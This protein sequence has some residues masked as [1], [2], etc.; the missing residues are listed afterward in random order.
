MIYPREYRKDVNVVVNLFRPILRQLKI[1]KFEDHD[2]VYLTDAKQLNFIL[3]LPNICITVLFAD[4]EKQNGVFFHRQIDSDT[5]DC[6]IVINSRFY[7]DDLMHAKLCG[8]HEFC[9]FLALF[10]ALTSTSSIIQRETFSKRLNSRIDELNNGSFTSFYTA[11][12][13]GITS[14]VAETNNAHYFLGIEENDIDYVSIHK[15]LLFSKELFEE[16]FIDYE[17]KTFST[18]M[19]SDDIEDRRHGVELYIKMVH[20]A[21]DE[22]SVDRKIAADRAYKWAFD[23]LSK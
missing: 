9:H 20:K 14:D 22:K 19:K 11:L 18:L 1:R 13:Q 21:A 16:Y 5:Y 10:Y 7:N 2:T 15:N 4:M 12:T 8:V 17:Q 6:Y 23:Y 3:N